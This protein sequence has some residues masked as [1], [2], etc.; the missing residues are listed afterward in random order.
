[1][2][3]IDKS[4]E[5]AIVNLTID[6]EKYLAPSRDIGISITS[7]INSDRFKIGD[8]TRW[9]Y[10]ST[11][12]IAFEYTNNFMILSPTGCK[13]IRIDNNSDAILRCPVSHKLTSMHTNE[14]AALWHIVQSSKVILSD[15]IEV[16]TKEK[17]KHRLEVF[18]TFLSHQVFSADY[19]I[20]PNP[21]YCFLKSLH[22]LVEQVNDGLV[23]NICSLRSQ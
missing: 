15:I 20:F 3:V 18:Y 8:I 2:E 10:Q 14:I 6:D 13:D 4:V 12:K 22:T 23:E 7:C 19:S 9:Y 5:S 17:M 1:M 16:C 11:R 21:V